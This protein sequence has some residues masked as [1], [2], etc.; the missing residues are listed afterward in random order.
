MS[1]TESLERLVEENRD[2]LLGKHH[3]WERVRLA[4]IA[5]ILNGYRQLP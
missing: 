4:D 2:H 3:G 5:E 1:F